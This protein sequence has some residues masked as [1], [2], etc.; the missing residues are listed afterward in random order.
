[1]ACP[2]CQ[3]VVEHLSD[4]LYG[5]TIQRCGCGTQYLQPPAVVPVPLE[6]LHQ[7]YIG[8]QMGAREAYVCAGCGTKN[9]RLVKP[10]GGV[11]REYCD[12]TSCRK[13]SARFR[14]QLPLTGIV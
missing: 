12:K 3:Q 4:R 8:V 13:K 5:R 9:M 14:N 2:R 10:R 11:R 6:P 7:R 1:M